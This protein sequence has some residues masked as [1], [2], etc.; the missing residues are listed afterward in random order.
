MTMFIGPGLLSEFEHEL[1][2][3]RRFLERV[4]AERLGWK[5]HEKSLTAGQLA[6]HI[7]QVPEGVLRLTLEDVATPPD[8]RGGPPQPA[9]VEEVLS[10]LDT[11]AAF[12]RR[13]LPTIDDARMMKEFRVV[14]GDKV[15]F[16]AP[17]AA[18]LRAIMFNHV[19][20]H[21]GQLGVY[22]R[23]V[24]AKVPSSYGPSGDESP[25]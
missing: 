11:S 12:V 21:R 19:Y 25:F 23:L 17:R 1:P 18:F 2:T 24:G 14:A 20:H 4:P 6:L 22:L 5:P 13:T 7:A 3:T 9:S 10:A 16:A 15:L 8:F